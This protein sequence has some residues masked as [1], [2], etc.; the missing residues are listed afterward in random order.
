FLTILTS[1]CADFAAVGHHAPE[2]LH[3]HPQMPLG[4]VLLQGV[5]ESMSP[6]ILGFTMLSL[7]ALITTLGLYRAS[8][9]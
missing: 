7:A 1:I 3:A 4:E 6:G 9:G 5:A 2:F 8:G